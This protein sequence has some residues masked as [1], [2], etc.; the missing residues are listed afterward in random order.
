MTMPEMLASFFT[1]DG[2][3]TSE[4]RLKGHAV[5]RFWRWV[6][7][8]AVALRMPSDLGYDDDGF[9]LPPLNLHQVTVKCEADNEHLFAMEAQGLMERRQ[10]RAASIEDRVRAC[11]ELVAREP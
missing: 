7:S 8:W 4:W 2:G 5:D 1:H 3:N 6:A 10:A 11:A 9:V